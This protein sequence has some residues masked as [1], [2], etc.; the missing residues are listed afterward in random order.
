M[1]I[2]NKEAFERTAKRLRLEVPAIY[3]ALKEK[4]TPIFAKVLAAVTVAY[5]LSPIDLIPDVIPVLG[6]LDDLLILPFLAA[7]TIRFIPK[8]V[9]E[10]C[11]V[12]A[13]HLWD[14]KKP[15]KWYYAGLIVFIWLLVIGLLVWKLWR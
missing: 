9:L 8:P 6:Y 13:E 5:A 3:L 12:R 2:F 10:D 4:Q 7:V 11:R 15:K 1:K 14:E